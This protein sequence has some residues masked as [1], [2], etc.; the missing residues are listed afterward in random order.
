MEEISGKVG[1]H[2]AK[3]VI[4]LPRIYCLY[5]EQ[6]ITRVVG[7]EAHPQDKGDKEKDNTLYLLS[8]GTCT[9]L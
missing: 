7:E 1:A 8:E 3:E 5:P 9:R 4:R 6:R 2:Y